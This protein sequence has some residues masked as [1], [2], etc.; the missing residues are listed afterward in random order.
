MMKWRAEAASSEM[1]SNKLREDVREIKSSE[2]DDKILEFA[3]MKEDLKVANEYNERLKKQ[4]AT[5]MQRV[6][7]LQGQLLDAPA[8][9]DED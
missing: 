2:T 5:A 9:L 1:Q 4:L 8:E 6:Y 7:E 3:T